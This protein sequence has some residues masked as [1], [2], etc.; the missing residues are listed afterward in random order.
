MK[1]QNMARTIGLLI[2]VGALILFCFFRLTQNVTKEKTANTAK[3]EMEKLISYDFENEYPKTV[4]DV[5]KLYCR[6]LKQVY[7]KDTKEDELSGL[8]SAMR[9]LYAEEMKEYTDEVSQLNTLKQDRK[10]NQEDKKYIIG[11]VIEEASQ[12]T[13]DTIDGVEYAKIN[14]TLNAKVGTTSTRIDQVYALEKDG[15]DHWKIYGWA[16]AD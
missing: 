9:N 16:D 3:T 10:S 5:M 4:R 12:I 1:K 13:Y 11:S 15:L 7:A 2:I 8:V 6:Y 14:I